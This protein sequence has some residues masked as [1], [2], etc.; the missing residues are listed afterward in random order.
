MKSLKCEELALIHRI[1]V[2]LTLLQILAFRVSFLNCQHYSPNHI[3]FIIELQMENLYFQVCFEAVK[4]TTAFL[5]NNDKEQSIL[6]HFK[7]LLPFLI[8][9]SSMLKC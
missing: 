3:V 9:V 4:A 8:Q 1:D 6:N 2:P 5:V 7:D